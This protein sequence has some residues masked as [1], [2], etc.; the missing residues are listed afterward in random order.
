MVRGLEP[1]A[2][3]VVGLRESGILAPQLFETWDLQ[4]GFPCGG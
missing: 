4:P 2:A 1:D 3:A